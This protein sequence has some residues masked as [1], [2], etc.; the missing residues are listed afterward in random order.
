MTPP[1]TPPE[2]PVTGKTGKDMVRVTITLNRDNMETF[3][4][5]VAMYEDSEDPLTARIAKTARRRIT[6]TLNPSLP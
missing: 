4:A 5:I 1:T 2:Q 6:A 3:E